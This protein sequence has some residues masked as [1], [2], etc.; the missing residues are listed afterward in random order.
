MSR[1]RPELRTWAWS[2]RAV[3]PRSVGDRLQREAI[4]LESIPSLDAIE[5]IR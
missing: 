5:G 3:A 2:S 4:V 1:P